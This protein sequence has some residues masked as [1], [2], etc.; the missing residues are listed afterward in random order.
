[1]K[2]SICFFYCYCHNYKILRLFLLLLQLRR[3]SFF[4]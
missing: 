3:C 2:M 1:M 4:V